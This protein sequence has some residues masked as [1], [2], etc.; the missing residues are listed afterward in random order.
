MLDTHTFVIAAHGESEYLEDCIK[1]IFRQTVYSTVIM[2]ASTDTK[3]IRDLSE[4]YN[5]PLYINEDSGS[6]GKDW[7]FCLK[8]SKTPY[9]TIAHQDDI[10][11]REYTER[12]IEAFREDPDSAITFTAYHEI[13]NGQ[14][15]PDNLNL[16]VKKILLEPFKRAG[17]R[18]S[19]KLAI[20]FGNAI[21]CPSVTYNKDVIKDYAFDETMHSDL[22]WKAW[23]DFYD[24]GYG[25]TYIP[26]VLMLHR[27]HP[28]SET[29][30]IIE[31]DQREREDLEVFEMMWPKRI[32]KG[33]EKIYKLG[34]W[35]NRLNRRE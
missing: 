6:I 32:A 3:H 1:S 26:K 23:V 25:F 22:D 8:L 30:H 4:K 27:I 31:E 14:V 16:K 2:A 21:A 28:E 15:V 7:N 10:Y 11:L 5:I 19:Q 35:G 33:I 29:T 17:S 20:M 12:V 9:V 34:E 13:R 18:W 24:L